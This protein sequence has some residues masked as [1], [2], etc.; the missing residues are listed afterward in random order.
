M[1]T[2]V[3]DLQLCRL[4]ESPRSKLNGGEKKKKKKKK[5]MRKKKIIKI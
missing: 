1:P 5:K 3:A 2:L 4:N